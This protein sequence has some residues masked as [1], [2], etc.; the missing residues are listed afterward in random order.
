MKIPNRNIAAQPSVPKRAQVPAAE[1]ETASSPDQLVLVYSGNNVPSLGTN[2]TPVAG[3]Y[4]LLPELKGLAEKTKDTK[5]TVVVQGYEKLETGEWETRRYRIEHGKVQDETSQ[6]DGFQGIYDKSTPPVF[7]KNIPATGES[8]SMFSRKALEDFMLDAMK[9]YPKAAHVSLFLNAHGAPT[10]NFGGEAIIDK[11]WQKVRQEEVSVRDFGRALE[12]V[13]QQTGNR[14]G[15][16][17]INTCEMGKVEN[18][19][20]LGRH[21]DFMI[22]SPQ[23]EFVPKGHENTAAFQDIVGATEHLLAHSDT[24]AKELGKTIIDLTTAKTTFEEEGKVENPIPTLELVDTKKLEA[25]SASLDKAGRKLS[26]MLGEPEPRSKVVEALKNSFN[27]REQVVDLKGFL[28]AVDLPET[29]ELANDFDQAVEKS[30]AGKFRGRDYSQAGP[31]AFF[32]PSFPNDRTP[33]L[34]VPTVGADPHTL[35]QDMTHSEIPDKSVRRWVVQQSGRLNELHD[36]LT[37]SFPAMLEV[38]PNAD[39]QKALGKVKN[40]ERL[41]QLDQELQKHIFGSSRQQVAPV[42]ERIAEAVAPLQKALEGVDLAPWFAD[43]EA[44]GGAEKLKEAALTKAL[45]KAISQAMGP[46]KQY[47]A[48]DNLPK[49]WKSFMEDLA[50]AVVDEAW[51]KHYS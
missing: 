5:V 24:G 38:V 14:L 40:P 17:D 33:P 12:S 20:E 21:A 47:Q 36:S 44:A 48:M 29:R 32:A 51:A 2:G 37:S 50:H 16:L 34:L 18:F 30:F 26:A 3:S 6:I 7:Q 13:E 45:D 8:V 41:L 19:L 39:L 25:V 10:P 31:V 43:I 9:P 42:Q 22:A 28:R 11:Q 15:L 4:R 49:G 1:D 27:F 35:L 23:N 46:V